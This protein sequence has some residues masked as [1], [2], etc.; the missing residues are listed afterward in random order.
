MPSRG[1]C[2]IRRDVLAVALEAEADRTLLDVLKAKL[3][4]RSA[5]RAC[6]DGSCGACRVILD[7]VL[8]SSCRI[9]WGDVAEGARVETYEQLASDPDAA[10][11]VDAFAEERPSRC[12]M[13]V[14][15]LGVTAVALARSSAPKEGAIEELI[16]ASD[17][18][19]HR[20]RLLASRAVEVESR[21]GGDAVVRSGGASWWGAGG[22]GAR[23]PADSEERLD[24]GRRAT[25]ER[26]SARARSAVAN[27]VDRAGARG[28][29]LR[30]ED[31][32]G[33]AFCAAFAPRAI[34]GRWGRRTRRR[35]SSPR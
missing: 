7:G 10:R 35:R 28:R 5:S 4:V 14:G 21:C 18:R 16:A 1:R 15:A 11:A 33:E 6:Q 32:L 9:S 2:S 3:G 31:P 22:A 30:G 27:G 25:E 24:V 23:R 20:T 34:D 26:R 29:F 17:V 8:V 13:C 19:V 12:R